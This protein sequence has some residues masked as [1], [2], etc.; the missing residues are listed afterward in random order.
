MQP[1]IISEHLFTSTCLSEAVQHFREIFFSL[2]SVSVVS[3]LMPVGCSNQHTPSD[4]CIKRHRCH[5]CHSVS[6]SAVTQCVV[7]SP[8][9]SNILRSSCCLPSL[10][11]SLLS[12]CLSS[13]LLFLPLLASFWVSLFVSLPS[14]TLS[15]YFPPSHS[16]SSLSLVRRQEVLVCVYILLETHMHAHVQYAHTHTHQCYSAHAHTRCPHAQLIH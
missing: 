2:V 7:F 10:Y 5:L 12:M 16:K 14:V 11:V 6:L 13:S 15:F 8:D 1:C 3:R 4:L 9:L